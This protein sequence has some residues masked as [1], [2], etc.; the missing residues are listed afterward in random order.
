MEQLLHYCWKH[1]LFPTNQ[2]TTTDGRRVEVVDTGLHN[3][4]AGPDFFNAKVKI[5][6]TMW[7]GNVE[8]HDKASDWYLHQHDNDAHYDNV[9]LHVCSKAD[10]EVVTK[11]GNSVPQIE[12]SV[13]ESVKQNYE[14][15]LKEDK[16]PPCYK[17][18]PS[19][20]NLMLHSWMSA[21]Q[22]ERLEEKTRLIAERAAKAGGDWEKAFFITLARN[23]GFGV[24]GD[25]FEVWGET[26]DL[27]AAAHHRDNLFQIEAIFMGQAGFLTPDNIPE[28]MRERALGEDYFNKL[29]AEYQYLAHK[30]TLKEMDANYWRFLRLRPQNFP[31]IRIAQLA[32]LYFSRKAQ[33]STVS[34]ATT[35]EQVETVLQTQV[36]PYWTRHFSFGNESK[37][38]AKHLSQ[39][40]LRLIIIN[41]VVPMLFAYGKY[42]SEERLIDR[43]FDFLDAT[44]AEENNIVRMWKECGLPVSTAGDSQAL[45]QLKRNYCERRDCLRCRI[46]YE[47]LR[48]KHE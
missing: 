1:K 41:T 20:T 30:F 10:E 3:H 17:I 44:K 38:S 23:F 22:T 43:S 8:I 14:L 28:R 18:V 26:V 25:A 24:N 45:I 31:H 32:N 11:A 33:L 36:T 7:V 21:L 16:Y 5:D 47:Y 34:S 27:N 13:P 37:P 12:I 15:L 42:R 29:R 40:S 39:S 48:K 35:I 4:N 9:V 2:L 6:E 19:L 46:G